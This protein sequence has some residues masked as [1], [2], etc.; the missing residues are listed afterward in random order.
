M[1]VECG[2]TETAEKAVMQGCQATDHHVF[3]ERLE[4]HLIVTLPYQLLI[5]GG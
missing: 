2:K 3:G 1:E 5:L 4:T